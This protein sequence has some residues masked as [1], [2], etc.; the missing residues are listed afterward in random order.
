MIASAS[1]GTQTPVTVLRR[2]LYIDALISA[3]VG[4]VLAAVPGT[5]LDLLG[6]P[7]PPDWA[8]LRLLG[9]AAITLALLMVLVGHR[10]EELWWW[11]WAFVVLEAGAAAVGTLNAA[12]SLAPG[13]EAWPWWTFAVLSWAF[14]GWIL[15]GLAR[16]GVE[17]QP[18]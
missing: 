8:W 13:A 3:V 16:S 17:R 2:A 15:W 1:R 10:V 9:V 14:A 6:Q 12:F 5:F 18:P 4:S 7:H 11:S